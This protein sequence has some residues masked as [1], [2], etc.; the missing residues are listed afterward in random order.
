VDDSSTSTVPTRAKV[1]RWTARILSAL[2]LLFWGFFIV[3]HFFGDGEEASRPLT[4]CD[5][6][7]L[8]TMGAWLVGLAVAWKWE[9]IGGVVTIVA[10]LIAIAANPAVLMFLFIPITA[11]LFLASWWMR[12]GPGDRMTQGGTSA[13]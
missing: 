8:M 7:G 5:Y 2:I 1:A 13:R 3:A 10:Y 9:F 12:R 4:A 11:M 6:V